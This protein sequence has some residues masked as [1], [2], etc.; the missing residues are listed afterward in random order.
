MI[1]Y[2]VHN[3]KSFL[4][5]ICII[6][7]TQLSV[8][9]LICVIR[10]LGTDNVF[11]LNKLLPCGLATEQPIKA[12]LDPLLSNQLLIWQK[13]KMATSPRIRKYITH[14][15]CLKY[16]IPLLKIYSWSQMRHH[17]QLRPGVTNLRHR[18]YFLSKHL[19]TRFPHGL[20][21]VAYINSQLDNQNL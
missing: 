6:L 3:A 14:S 2:I 12:G 16:Y 10:C 13:P 17:T 11:P 5:Q 1:E 19:R 9:T 8:G 15:P 18:T 21:H 20:F 7:T 4:N